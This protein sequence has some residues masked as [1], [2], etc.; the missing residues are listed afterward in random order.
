MIYLSWGVMY[1]GQ[2]DSAYFDALIPRLMDDIV[3]SRGVA[4]ASIPTTPAVRIPRGSV[5]EVAQRACDERQ[6]YHLIFIH[7][8]TGGRALETGVGQRA[9]SY[10]EAIH[11]TC[12]WPQ[13]RCVTI[14]PR[15]E[16]EAW[17]LADPEAVAA[18]LGYRGSTS[19]IGLPSDA[20]EAETLGD[21]KSVLSAVARKIRG[22]RRSLSATDLYPAIAQRQ[23]FDRLRTSRSFRAYEANL[24]RALA[25]LGCI[26]FE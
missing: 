5:G 25:S 14:T 3:L 26:S 1:E 19:E 11:R 2:T 24:C 4:S 20:A 16:T 21:P 17:V 9:E 7:A 13:E 18:A 8:D 12:H 6:A 23:A 22:R 10:C 15:Q